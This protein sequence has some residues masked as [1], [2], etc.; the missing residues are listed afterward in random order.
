[1][2]QIVL[3]FPGR[4]AAIEWHINASYPLYSAEARTRFRS[5]PPP[6]NGGYATP[7]AWIDGKSRGYQYSS[8]SSWAQ[9]QMAIPAE[10][11]IGLTGSYTP[12]AGSGEL[13]IELTNPT[14]SP[15]TADLFVVI[16]EDSI[17]YSAPNGDPWHNH[18]C[19]QFA[20]GVSGTSV[21]IPAMTTDTV[22]QNFAIE[23]GWVEE[24]CNLVAYLQTPDVQ[25][26]SSRP[27]HQGAIIRLL[28]LTGI[29][30][31]EPVRPRLAVTAG[32]NPVRDR[33]ELHFNARPGSS[34]RLAVY[35]STGRRV[36]SLQGIAN[37]K[38]IVTWNRR[39][40]SGSRVPAGVYG[41]RL[42]V[43]GRTA[44]GKLVTTD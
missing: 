29:A 21:T 31:R 25:P 4:I 26:D 2:D 18:V 37:G 24:R 44:Q 35:S 34:W 17:Y 8:W 41:W 1:M 15:V 43:D 22:I 9:Y 13:A 14:S 39:D 36:A 11:G 16:T 6:Y 10:Y 33:A 42:T 38:D 28:E 19:R 20:T 3:D 27:I 12:G 23:S 5:Y 7:W 32:P 30:E 40:E